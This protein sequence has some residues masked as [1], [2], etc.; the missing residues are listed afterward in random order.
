MEII[1]RDLPDLSSAVTALGA[2]AQTHRLAVFRELV[3]AGSGGVAA[4]A[5]AERLNIPSSSLSFHLSALKKG[6]LI[7][8]R[9][10]G[11]SIIYTADYAAM[12]ALVAFLLRNC[13]AGDA[14]QSELITQFATGDPS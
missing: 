10:E 3:Q 11:R 9:R 7:E 5:L 6:G 14:A 13:C 1:D 8:E 2:L 12:H 4:G